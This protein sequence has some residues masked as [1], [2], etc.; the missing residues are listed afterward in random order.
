MTYTDRHDAIAREITEPIEAGDATAAEFDIDAIADEVIAFDAGT[1]TYSCTVDPAEFW[2]IVARHAITRRITWTHGDHD[3]LRAEDL[4][5]GEWQ[6]VDSESVDATEDPA[7]YDAAEAKLR[8]A[9]G[10]KWADVPV[11]SLL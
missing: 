10:P 5:D 4:E 2:A 6:E 1:R 3:I 7:P 8:A 9:L 11:E